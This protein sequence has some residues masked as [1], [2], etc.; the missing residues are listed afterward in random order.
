MCAA[1]PA[2]PRPSSPRPLPARLP[3]PHPA[4]LAPAQVEGGGFRRKSMLPGAK[5]GSAETVVLPS[6]EALSTTYQAPV[7]GE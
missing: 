4:S 5:S 6:K 1:A 3:P 2:R 7:E